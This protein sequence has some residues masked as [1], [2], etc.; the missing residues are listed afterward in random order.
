MSRHVTR[1]KQGLSLLRTDRTGQLRELRKATIYF[2]FLS[3]C[4]YILETETEVAPASLAV[5]LADA[6]ADA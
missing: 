2:Y 5:V 6:C 4:F 3:L 1:Y